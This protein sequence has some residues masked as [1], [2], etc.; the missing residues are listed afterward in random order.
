MGE[1]ISLVVQYLHAQ[2]TRRVRHT[3]LKCYFQRPILESVDTHFVPKKSI[4][5]RSMLVTSNTS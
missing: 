2:E 4:P 5:T 3:P 1:D